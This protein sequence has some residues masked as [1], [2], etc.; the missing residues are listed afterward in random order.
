MVLMVFTISFMGCRTLI[1]T[2]EPRASTTSSGLEYMVSR[3]GN[4]VT[5][6][7]GDIV[8]VHYIGKLQD[9]TVFDSSY[10]RDEPISFRIGN[11][12]VIPGL[13]EGVLLLGEGGKATLVVPPHLAYGSKS[14]GPVPANST[15]TF[16]IELLEVTPSG[17]SPEV[18]GLA[19][20]KLE[21]GLEYTVIEK[22]KGEAL[23][24]GMR[25]SVHYTGYLEDETIFDSSYERGKPIQFILGKGMVIS[26]WDQGLMQLSVGDKARL[27]IPYDLAYGTTGR[28]PIPPNSNLIF[29]VEVVD[30]YIIEPPRP[31]D[32]SSLDT[33]TTQSGLQYII[34]KKGSGEM[35]VPGQILQV[36]YSGYLTDGTLF[37]SSVQRGE[38]FRFV[39]GQGQVIRGWDEGFLLLSRGAKARFIIPPDMAYGD[40]DMGVIPPGSTLVFDVELIDF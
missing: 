34:V 35:P 15:L 10:E 31:F 23:K 8:K 24:E 37:D 29:D 32:V 3:K 6:G 20:T 4:R 26:G 36:H 11:Q 9:G 33:N 14:Y 13:E 38:P 18:A 19:R 2:P 39:V 27:Y 21:S 25:V 1:P 40:R 16:E 5:P 12:Q 17:L 28:D 30:G 7:E 22:G